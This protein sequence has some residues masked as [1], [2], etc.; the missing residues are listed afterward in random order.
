MGWNVVYRL[1]RKRLKQLHC[2]KF[3][4]TKCHHKVS[5]KR[6][7]KKVSQMFRR[8]VILSYFSKLAR[9]EVKC[10]QVVEEQNYSSWCWS[11]ESHNS[12]ACSQHCLLASLLG[13]WNLCKLQHPVRIPAKEADYQLP[14]KEALAAWDGESQCQGHWSSEVCSRLAQGFILHVF[15]PSLTRSPHDILSIGPVWLGIGTQ[16]IG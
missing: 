16:M 15:G 6:R 8:W 9:L 7:V 1:L 12:N 13:D 2:R 3:L 11:F 4:L 5:S 10:I 14:N